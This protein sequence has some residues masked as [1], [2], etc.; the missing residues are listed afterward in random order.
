M[1]KIISEHLAMIYGPLWI[2]QFDLLWSRWDHFLLYNFCNSTS[3][4][5]WY[6]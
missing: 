5:F 4:L 3:L 6:I 2:L 1:K